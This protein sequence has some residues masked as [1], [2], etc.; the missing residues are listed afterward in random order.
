MLCTC[1]NRFCHGIEKIVDETAVL[2]PHVSHDLQQQVMCPKVERLEDIHGAI[3]ALACVK[4][5]NRE[6]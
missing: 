5:S 1:L 2:Q 4:K 3:Y 6:M